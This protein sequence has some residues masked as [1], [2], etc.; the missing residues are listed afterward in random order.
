MKCPTLCAVKYIQY[1]WGGKVKLERPEF[2]YY[3]L[4]AQKIVV[5][6]CALLYG[7]VMPLI[8][9]LCL[10]FL[11]F[12]FLYDRW[13]IV[14]L[15][16]KDL[17]HDSK[18]LFYATEICSFYFSIVPVATLVIIS[19]FFI[20]WPPLVSCLITFSA[21]VIALMWETS[22]WQHMNQYVKGVRRVI[23]AN[24]FSACKYFEPETPDPSS[25]SNNGTSLPQ[26]HE[27]LLKMSHA[28][29]SIFQ[30]LFKEVSHMVQ[31]KK[32]NHRNFTVDE[33]VLKN[34]YVHPFAK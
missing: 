17:F 6:F 10:V 8:L 3:D 5:M 4:Y 1:W 23:K 16:E 2:D 7:S 30:Q 33:D 31:G 19:K 22:R 21:I 34:A 13:T 9:P 20:N 15:H 32:V 26:W 27:H 11:I 28:T 18:L 29:T 25:S 24:D 14:A 12:T